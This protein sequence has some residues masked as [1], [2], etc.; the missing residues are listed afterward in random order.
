MTTQTNA[1]PETPELPSIEIKNRWT[2]AILHAGKYASIKEAVCAAVAKRAYLRGAYLRGAYLQGAYLQGA[3][4]QGADLQGAD[5]QGA[6]LQGAYLQGAYLRGAD[7]QGADLRGADL[8]GAYLQGAYLR[9]ADLQ[10]AYLRG[11]DLQGA[12]LRGAYLQGADLQ[13]A[14]GISPYLCQP[15]HI[16]RDQPGAIRA[17]KIITANGEGIYARSNGY[18]P[19]NYD[20]VSE[21][22]EPN[23]D[24]D[25][26][27][28][29]GKGIH[30]AT[31]DWCMRE[32]KPGY[33]I[34]VMEF[35]AE[36]I[37]CIP[38][39]GNGK[40]RVFRC[41]RV[42]EKDLVELGLIEATK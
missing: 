34:L 8:Q 16:L 26:N 11:A 27:Q 21:F 25:P 32:W 39:G 9:G 23:A 28:D 6:D 12:Y 29:C 17:Y 22:E 19:F 13:G 4:L 1:K 37:A 36:D 41:K 24:T 38:T 20:S 33:R 5:L 3:Y 42:G 7:L 31:L 15:L 30:L 14:T 18:T 40:F 2:G 10:G 35:A